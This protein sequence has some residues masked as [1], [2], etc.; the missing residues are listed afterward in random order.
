MC[1]TRPL[2]CTGPKKKGGVMNW[3]WQ[4]GNHCNTIAMPIH[5]WN[6]SAY[7]S[8]QWNARKALYWTLLLYDSLTSFIAFHCSNI[9]LFKHGS[10]SRS[11][12]ST[13]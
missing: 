2:P 1:E 13:S 5:A 3:P 6:D 12:D 7:L 11:S 10:G 4:R 9:S 8:S